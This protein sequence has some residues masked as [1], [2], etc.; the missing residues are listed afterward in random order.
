MDCVRA[1]SG[2]KVTVPA[3]C[4]ISYDRDKQGEGAWLIERMEEE[5]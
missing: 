2:D 1:S 4:A 5:R 3:F